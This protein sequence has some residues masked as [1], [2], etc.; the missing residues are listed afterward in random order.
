METFVTIVNS[1][2]SKFHGPASTFLGAVCDGAGSFQLRFKD[3]DGSA[4]DVA[5]EMTCTD[6]GDGIE[7]KRVL[8]AIAN[9][10]QGYG[11]QGKHVKIADD[12]TGKYIHPNLLSVDG[13]A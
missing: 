13:I 8:Q 3:I 11:V 2:T 7:M 9:S 1:A 12:V 10:M 4:A 5:I 6:A